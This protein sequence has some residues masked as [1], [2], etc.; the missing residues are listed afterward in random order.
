M[1]A[2][3]ELLS[4]DLITDL[5]SDLSANILVISINVMDVIN[6]RYLISRYLTIFIR[7]TL[8]SFKTR[9]VGIILEVIFGL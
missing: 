9:K 6:I 4:P 7:F 5:N 2:S 8:R 1:L 3:Y